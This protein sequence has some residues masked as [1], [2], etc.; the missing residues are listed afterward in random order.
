[1][2]SNLDLLS[3]NFSKT[4]V[5]PLWKSTQEYLTTQIQNLHFM[6][7]AQIHKNFGFLSSKKLTQSY[8]EITRF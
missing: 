3:S 6:D 2:V 7:S 1:M 4:V 5:G 8:M